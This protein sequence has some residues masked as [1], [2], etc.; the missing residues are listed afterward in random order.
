MSRMNW[1]DVSRLL[2]KQELNLEFVGEH[3]DDEFFHPESLV[4]DLHFLISKVA[5]EVRSD[6]RLSFAPPF[7]VHPIASL[8]GDVV[9]VLEDVEKKKQQ[10]A[11][12][13]RRTECAYQI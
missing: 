6:E 7:L 12:L 10:R 2:S 3:K 13:E 4:A 5:K 9:V 1:N 8:V 11:N